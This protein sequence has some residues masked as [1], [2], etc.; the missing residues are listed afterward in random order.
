[1]IKTLTCAFFLVLSCGLNA[2]LPNGTTAPDFD[3]EDVYGN[4]FSLYTMM[5]SNKSACIAFEATWCGYCWN[6]HSSQVFASVANN[7]S[8]NT[9]LVML[10]SDWSTNDDCLF[11]L[12]SCNNYSWGNWVINEPYQ[13]CNLSATNGPNIASDYARNQYPLLYVISP[14][15]RTWEIVERTYQ[16]YANWITKSFAL[17]TTATITNSSC[18]DNGKIILNPT[19]GFG[20]LSYKWSNGSTNKDLNN[21]AGGSYTVII[22]DGNKYFKEFGPF[23]VDGPAR[24]V[25]VTNAFLT[26]VKCFDE[27]TGS[28]N[29]QVDY[30]TPS[31]SYIWSNGNKTA[32]LDNLKA[33][34]YTLTVTDSKSCTRIKS[35]SINQPADL[36]VSTTSTKE[37]CDNLDG[38]IEVKANGGVSPYYFNR[39]EGDQTSP[40]F[41]DLK[42]GRDYKITVTDVNSCTEVINA[43]VEVTHRPKSNAGIDKPID[44]IKDLV[45]L[46]GSQ[47]DNGNGFSILWTTVQGNIVKGAKTLTPEV[48]LPGTYFLRITDNANKCITVDSVEVM[49]KRVFPDIF[50]SRDTTLNCVFVETEL[51][52]NSNHPPVKFYWTK[53]DDSLFLKSGN[54]LMVHDT[55]RYIFHAKDTINLCIAVDTIE[56]KK[57]DT[58][59]EAIAIVEKDVSCKNTE[60]IIDGAFSS[61]GSKYEYNWSTRDGNIVR[62]ANSTMA[63][64]DKGGSYTLEVT[65]KLNFCKSNTSVLVRQQ[66]TPESNFDQAISSLSAQFNDLSQ[67]VPISWFWNFGDGSTS[68]VQNPTH[69][70]SIEGEFEV[71]LEVNNDCGKNTRCKKILIG[72]S[73][74]LNLASKILHPV[75]CFGGK[76]GYISIKVQGGVPPYSYLWNNQQT[77]YEIHDLIAGDYSVQITDQQGT[78]LTQTFTIGQPEELKISNSVINHV[79]AGNQNGSIQL[80][81]SGGTQPYQFLWSNNS[82]DNPVIKLNAGK[83][84]CIV[85]DA[86]S[87]VKEFGPFEVKEI[88]SSYN[89]KLINRFELTPNPVNGV[90]LIHIEL[91]KSVSYTLN[92]MN[93]YG[94]T[95][96]SFHSKAELIPV[97]LETYPKGIYFIMLNCEGARETIKCVVD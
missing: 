30:G 55:G 44:C 22:T 27:S 94:E 7:L 95:I 40:K 74:T 46:D 66:T 3:V 89:S 90:G 69:D 60:I 64:V 14:D 5:G 68:T 93:V 23:I 21:I 91:Q 75:S 71:C 45:A 32:S 49:D 97:N 81:I 31:Y 41:I 83:Y 54:I 62:G 58:L 16:N 15:K 51:K 92:M 78:R 59:P 72:I 80:E 1:M 29:V 88:T 67:G 86:N 79:D 4:T 47:S 87:C 48:N 10:E 63:S 96:W 84:S 18:G 77:A 76:D 9:V 56:I 33:G 12:G 38:V 57:N 52:G 36:V 17:N 28:I 34:N 6:F 11:G 39:G 65:D 43:Y 82:T 25:D 8:A 24:R 50:A 19:G 2:Q 53:F 13:I 42:G 73:A 85:T 37:S 35:Y 20:F 26:Q 61:Q 70:Y